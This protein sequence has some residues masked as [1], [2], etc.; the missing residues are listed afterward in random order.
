MNRA[1]SG[2]SSIFLLWLPLAVMWILMAIEQPAIAAVLARMSE[3][4]RQLAAFG[5]TYSL[6]L[7]IEGPIIQMLAAGTAVADCRENYR[8]LFTL[9]LLLGLG[10]TFVQ[11]ILC[12]PAVYRPFALNIIGIPIELIEDSRLAL[13]V[14][15]PWGISVGFRRLWQG[16]LIR[17]GRTRV[18]PV[19]MVLRILTS[20]TVLLIG[21]RS[22]IVPGA[23]LGGL[24]LSAG[25]IVGALS[26]WAYARPIIRK[27]PSETSYDMNWKKLLIFYIP[28]AL[29]SFI[30]LGA[31]PIMQIGLARGPMPLESLALFPV[32]MGYLFLFNSF[33]MSS[34]EVV[35]ARLEGNDSRKALLRFSLVLSLSLFLIY[36]LLLI[37]PIW[38]LWFIGV[39]GLSHDLSELAPL[40]IVLGIPVVPLLAII[41]L[42]RGALVRQRRTR[43]VTAGTVVNVSVLLLGM[44]I[45]VIV[46]PFPAVHT[47][48]AAYS[49]AFIAEFIFLFFR[50]PLL[51]FRDE[52]GT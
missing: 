4:K 11:A 30:T 29:V 42:Y 5:F 12:I 16:V 43:E 45:G 3:A 52:L 31:R 33:S 39:S 47:V 14:M 37:G 1:S 36:I 10:I 15:L 27:I 26:A 17:Y 22:R 34:Q 49:L 50:K 7:F 25:V 13:L 32:S 41:A 20:F 9:M 8:R 46:L 48:F 51:P 24:A 23:V 35:I 28:L 21:Y 18:I 40:S 44:F 2:Q 6:A 38:K 19:T